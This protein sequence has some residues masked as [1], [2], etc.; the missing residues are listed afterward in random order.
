MLQIIINKLFKR[1]VRWEK[2]IEIDY[3]KLGKKILWKTQNRQYLK[4]LAFR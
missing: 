4:P 2:P 1:Q 3:Y